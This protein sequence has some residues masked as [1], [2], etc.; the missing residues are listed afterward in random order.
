MSWIS[1]KLNKFI[2]ERVVNRAANWLKGKKTVI[3]AI[4]LLLWA[5]IYAAP[6]VFPQYAFIVPIAEQVRD[7]LKAAGVDLDGSL[8]SA[9]VGF[10]VVGLIDKLRKLRNKNKDN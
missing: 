5:V 2:L 10:T 8:F 4:S 6:I 3:G 9:G 7:A 1:D